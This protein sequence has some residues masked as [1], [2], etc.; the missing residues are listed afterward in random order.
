MSND[1]QIWTDRTRTPEERADDLISRLSLEEK[2]GQLLHESPSIERLGIP[3][4]NWWNECLHGVAR[5]GRATIF[6]QAIALAATFDTELLREV[7]GVISDE[8]R[9]KYYAAQAVGRR[10]QYQGLTFWTPNVNIFRD[11]RWGRGQETYGEDP[12]LTSRMGVAFVQGIQQIRDGILKAAACAKHF[13]VHSGP[14]GLR[15]EFDARVTA[16]DL[17]ETYLPAFETLVQEARVEAVMGAY[18]RTNGE[19]CCASP[20][21]LQTILREEWGFT[22]HV[23][24]D[25]WAIRDIHEHHKTTGSP[26]ESVALAINT[27]CDLNCGSTYEYALEAVRNGLLPEAAID[28]ALRRVL[29]TR[30]KLG[31]L[32][33]RAALPGGG[34]GGLA[35][36]HGDPWAE[37][38]EI[39]VD[40]PK[41]RA[42]ARRAAAS[43]M[44][45]LKNNGVL[46]LRAELSRIYVTG[47]N[48][49][50]PEALLGNYYG[51]TAAVVTPV[52]GIV[53][54]LPP[55]MSIDYRRG[56]LLDREKPN[57]ADWAVF[58]AGVS[59]VAIVFLGL[60][61]TLE[62]E[63]GDA[64]ASTERGDRSDLGLPEG[65]AAYLRRIKER[66]TPVVAVL[67]GGS[68]LAIGEIHEL[69]DAVL[70]AWYPGAEGGNAIAD[71]LF[72]DTAPHGNLPVTFYERV[73][74]LPPYED[75]RMDGR[76]YRYFGGTPLYPFG[77][78]LTYTSFAFS[79]LCVSHSPDGAIT[80]TVRIANSGGRHGIA[81]VQLYLIPPPQEFPTP[82]ASL[83]GFRKVALAPGE[84]QE[85]AIVL[86]PEAWVLYDGDG[87]ARYPGGEWTISVGNC[88]PGTRG[89]ELGA[90]QPCQQTIVIAG[91]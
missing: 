2:A 75:Y 37:L 48:A 41:H 19:P 18:N 73:S 52:E 34:A 30:F 21:L 35:V 33:H 65:Q 14:E 9:A 77:F 72:G 80:A 58:E 24:S 61:G 7:A 51:L 23:V 1:Y 49:F 47:P 54:R 46:P 85:V 71:I 84:E 62:G 38:A 83:K 76:T 13:A 39:A 89:I 53:N 36:D 59:D 28:R 86:P 74:D 32:D 29:I 15:H 43:S 26:Q 42:V 17:R 79:H 44:V 40:S 69:A 90:A 55:G 8:G 82:R 12:F 64:I 81:T 50:N 6:P 20:T 60:D 27:G 5:A 67:T 57:P 4:Y 88:S 70:M 68:A 31:V 66:G 16:Q 45:L 10:G 87:V 56:A 91:R 63:E 22:G 11:P 78:G 3:Q 25:C